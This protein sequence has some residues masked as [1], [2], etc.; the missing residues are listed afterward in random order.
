MSNLR[1]STTAVIDALDAITALLN[2]G[3]YIELRSGAPPATCETAD[4]GT[5]LA[6]CNLSATAFGGATDGT[7]KATAVAN[8]ISADTSADADGT[9]GHYRAKT[10]GGSCVIQGDCSLTGLGGDLQFST[11]DVTTG[12]N[13]SI[14][15]WTLNI[16]EA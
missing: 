13:V 1:L 9:I 4:S 6:T 2:T 5:L 15:G 14:S 11:L 7:D 10:S 16:P 8:A 12:D 3:G